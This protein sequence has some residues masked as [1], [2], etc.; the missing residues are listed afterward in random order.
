MRSS[1]RFALCAV[2]LLFSALLV[3]ADKITIT[4][5]PPGAKVE[6][7]G[8]DVGVT[9]IEKGYPRYYFR[10]PISPLLPHLHHPL[11]ARLTLDGYIPKQVRL[12]EGQQ[13]WVSN[14]GRKRFVYYLLARKQFDIKLDRASEVFDGA[15]DSASRDSSVDELRA[16]SEI[17]SGDPAVPAPEYSPEELV[18]RCKPAVVLLTGREVKGSGFFVTD[19][20][21]IATNAHVANGEP[22]VTV[23]LANN[24]HVE[25]SVVYIDADL[26]IALVKIKGRNFPRLPLADT[27]AAKQGDPVLVIG[28][29]GL[30]LSFSATRGI[31]SAIG[32][33]P[34][35]GPGIWIQTDAAINPGNSGGPLLNSRGQVIGI[36]TWKIIKEGVTGIGFALSAGDLRNV[37]QR[38]YPAAKS[39]TETATAIEHVD[40]SAAAATKDSAGRDPATQS[41]QQDAATGSARSRPLQ[42]ATG[43]VIFTQSAGEI[44]IDSKYVGN[45]PAKVP[46]PSGQHE[47]LL[48]VSGQ[49]D[50]VRKINILPNVEVNF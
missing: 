2:V 34:D 28:N 9:P 16:T 23:S 12:T 20:G 15:I 3:R 21:L 24:R 13:E 47:I 1:S 8:E 29:P 25:G 49:A 38:F 33:I 10:D 50:T 46:L 42:A 27:F 35:Y 17:S 44:W 43:L 11:I 22:Y 45:T 5:N 39:S 14:N 30:S 48:R 6:I 32:R 41:P 4:S 36:A 37:L 40:T 31:V 18:E 26:D 19:T 7:D